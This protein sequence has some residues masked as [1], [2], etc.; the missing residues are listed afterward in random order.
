MGVYKALAAHNNGSTSGPSSLAFFRP[1]PHIHPIFK[2]TRPNLTT[3]PT[4]QPPNPYAP[5]D[6]PLLTTPTPPTPPP[7]SAGVFQTVVLA[8]NVRLIGK[9]SGAQL[10]V[11]AEDI[12][13]IRARTSQAQWDMVSM[14]CT[15]LYMCRCTIR[16][17]HRIVQSPGPPA[18]PYTHTHTHV[19]V[20]VCVC[21]IS[22]WVIH[23][24]ARP[25]DPPQYTVAREENVLEVLGRS[26][27]PS[28]YG[29]E[30]IK[31][32]LVLQAI[33]GT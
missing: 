33:G 6:P 1:F 31:K 17:P 5:T 32:A 16:P 21:L 9:D 11:S 7:T 14:M 30:F 19:C 8:N 28:I 22:P 25:P 12:G 13:H 24:P 27:A 26:L 15:R 4:P 29:H 10:K 18:P 20:R 2:A 3:T 23:P